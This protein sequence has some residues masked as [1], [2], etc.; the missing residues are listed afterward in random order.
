[1][2]RNLKGKIGL[3]LTYFCHS[4][5]EGLKMYGAKSQDITMIQ[6][7]AVKRIKDDDPPFVYPYAM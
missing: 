7:L 6:L 5:P 1:M 4:K 3:V 2:P